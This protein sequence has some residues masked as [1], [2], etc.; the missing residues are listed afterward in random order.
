MKYVQLLAHWAKADKPKAKAS[1][2]SYVGDNLYSYGTLIGRIVRDVDG[3]R[4]ALVSTGK[5]S[6]STTTIQNA[7]VRAASDEFIASFR[8]PELRVDDDAHGE[9]LRAYE[10]SAEESLRALEAGR[11]TSVASYRGRAK[12]IIATAAQYA[13][14]FGIS[15]TYAGRDPDAVKHKGEVA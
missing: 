12:A 10:A 6:D 8:V 11:L 4:V 14:T 15:W 2:T 13:A 9:N 7:A 1:S 5:W 3:K